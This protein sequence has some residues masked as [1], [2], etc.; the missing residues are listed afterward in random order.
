MTIVNV[1]LLIKVFLF[2]LANVIPIK[3]W[4]GDDERDDSLLK[5]KNLIQ[6]YFYS[7]LPFD[8]NELVTLS[9][10]HEV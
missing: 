8:V 2:N 9:I 1:I 6:N 10:S 5:I 3:S 4:N 7:G